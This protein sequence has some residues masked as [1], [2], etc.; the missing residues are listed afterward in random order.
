M[1]A[2]CKDCKGLSNVGNLPCN[3]SISQPL[4]TGVAS[5]VWPRVYQRWRHTLVSWLLLSLTAETRPSPPPSISLS[6]VLATSLVLHS[7]LTLTWQRS[8]SFV[9]FSALVD[10]CGCLIFL[11]DTRNIAKIS[12][13]S[14]LPHNGGFNNPKC[15][16]LQNWRDCLCIFIVLKAQSRNII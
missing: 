2:T 16:I 13:P 10:V 11:L 15:Q 4:M 9:A 14:L 5:A 1:S 7:L 6:L 12:L 3:H 8:R